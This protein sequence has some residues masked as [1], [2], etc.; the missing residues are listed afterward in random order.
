MGSEDREHGNQNAENQHN[1]A[2]QQN[3]E[4]EISAR[5][6]AQQRPRGQRNRIDCAE[7]DMA[8]QLARVRE[9]ERRGELAPIPEVPATAQ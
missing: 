1:P 2:E 8:E 6:D 9:M 5:F 7:A 3:P 4:P